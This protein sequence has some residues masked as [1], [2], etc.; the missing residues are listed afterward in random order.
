MRRSPLWF[1]GFSL[2]TLFAAVDCTSG[3]VSQGNE[4]CANN[5]LD[6]DQGETATDCGGKLCA[7]CAEG[8]ACQENTDCAEGL[9]CDTTGKKCLSTHCTN[10]TK[11]ADETDKDCGGASCP[12][13]GASLVCKANR[14]CVST[15]CKSGLCTG[16]S[17]TDETQNQGEIDVDCGDPNGLCPPC[18]AGLKCTDDKG[19]QSGIC[20]SGTCTEASCSD[21]IKNGTEGDV[22]CGGSCTTLCGKGDSCTTDADCK[23]SVCNE[24]CL[25]ASCA[26]QVKNGTETAVDCGGT[27]SPCLEAK[28]CAVD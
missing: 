23:S 9:S 7:P 25:D 13:C 6:E 3:Y 19:C 12:A 17:C 10:K 5:K 18:E 24:K 1:A 16:A 14:D 2:L 20:N 21:R 4:T 26:D 28:D 15:V 11:D 27:C 22:D 8:K